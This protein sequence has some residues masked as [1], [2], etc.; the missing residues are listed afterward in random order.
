MCGRAISE[1][2]GNLD[3]VAKCNTVKVSYQVT[4]AVMAKEQCKDPVL[5][6]VCQCVLASDKFRPED[7]HQI[8]FKLHE[9]T[10]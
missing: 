3:I 6:L 9:S 4:P 7:V 1:R 10:S 8:K 2:R 5:G